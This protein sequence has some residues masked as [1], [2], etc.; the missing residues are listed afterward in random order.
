MINVVPVFYS[1][2]LFSDGLVDIHD[3]SAVEYI[4]IIETTLSPVYKFSRH[5]AVPGLH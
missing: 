5:T 2:R 4:Y 1:T 3:V